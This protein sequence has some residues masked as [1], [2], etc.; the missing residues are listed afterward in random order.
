[1]LENQYVLP[2]A[3]AA[4]RCAGICALTARVR[5][6]TDIRI[7]GRSPLDIRALN[8]TFGQKTGTVEVQ[9][10]RT[11]VLASVTADIVPPFHD[12][13]NEVSA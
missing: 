3:A 6:G 13:P 7:D 10:G 8:I 5:C 12:R 4:L 9:I 1:M 2:R 11:R